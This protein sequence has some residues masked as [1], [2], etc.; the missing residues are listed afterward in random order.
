MHPMNS[1]LSS[2]VLPNDILKHVCTLAFPSIHLPNDEE[3]EDKTEDEK[4]YANI[5]KNLPIIAQ[6]VLSLRMTCKTLNAFISENLMSLLH[7]DTS[8]IDAFLIR[9]I[10]A[11]IPYF[12]KYALAHGADSNAVHLPNGYTALLCAIQNNCYS[13]CALLLEKDANINL[14]MRD[15]GVYGYDNNPDYNFN[16]PIHMAIKESNAQLVTLFIHKGANLNVR[17]N[18]DYMNT[19]L[20]SAVH[21]NNP[22]ILKTLLSSNTHKGYPHPWE[23]TIIMSAL[24][25]AKNIKFEENNLE[26]EENN[27]KIIQLL[28]KAQQS[29]EV[30]PIYFV[31]VK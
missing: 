22:I 19:L 27:R 21:I 12:T 26:K 29:A 6:E 24:T 15:Y 25:T 3:C 20:T 30:P 8:N 18:R 14:K 5:K 1:T 17:I 9:S 4:N 16:W 13:T 23:Y 2:V 7:L 31:W 10:Q 28:E 11:N